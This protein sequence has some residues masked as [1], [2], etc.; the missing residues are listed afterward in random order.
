MTV[1]KLK[2]I[3]INKN[4]EIETIWV[5]SPDQYYFLVHHAV[6]DLLQKGL[7]ETEQISEDEY[8]QM[9]AEALDAAKHEFLE[10][11]DIKDLPKA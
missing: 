10:N 7:V 2:K 6:N 5:L 11:I 1:V 4:G 3:D 8:K 9:Q